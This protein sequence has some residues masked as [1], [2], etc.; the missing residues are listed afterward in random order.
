MNNYGKFEG[1]DSIFDH[2]NIIPGRILSAFFSFLEVAFE[3][4]RS[5]ESH[6][7]GARPPPHP[8]TAP[9]HPHKHTRVRRLEIV[10]LRNGSGT[11]QTLSADQVLGSGCVSVLPSSRSD[12]RFRAARADLKCRGVGM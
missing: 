8:R 2:P 1:L 7:P 10:Q 6:G 12:V 5:N 11:R 4:S 3:Y 9:T